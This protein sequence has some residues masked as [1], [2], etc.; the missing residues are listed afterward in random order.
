MRFQMRV[1]D[2]LRDVGAL[3]LDVGCGKSGVDVADMAMDFADDVAPRSADARFRPLVVKDRCARSHR[4][5]RVE[6]RREFLVIDDKLAAAGLGRGLALRHHRRDTL[7]DETNH[8]VQ[9]GGVVRVG[10]LVFMSSARIKFFRR[11][12]ESQD[13]MHAGH[14]ERSIFVNRPD[15]RVRVRRTQKLEVQKTFRDDVERIARGTGDDGARRRRGHAAAAGI[16]RLGLLD[17]GDATNGVF[18]R[19]IAGAAADIAL[20]RPGQ[21]LPLRLIET[22]GRH[23]HARRAEAAL[24]T[25]GVEKRLLHRVQFAVLGQA[26][27]GR[28]FAVVGAISRE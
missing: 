26:F 21:I 8:P 13:G 6:D 24:E 11:V 18:D 16:A 1:L 23:D 5:V 15:S 19:A 17:R 20:Q 12:F 10:S 27:D 14:G 3:V 25:L 7:A 28:N 9:Q 2:P 22:R 4:L